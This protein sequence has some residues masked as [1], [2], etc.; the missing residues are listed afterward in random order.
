MLVIDLICLFVASTCSC[1]YMYLD[2]NKFSLLW[3][4]SSLLFAPCAIWLMFRLIIE[5]MLFLIITFKNSNIIEF[6]FS[7]I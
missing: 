6:L 3:N 7:N 2:K 4:I 5:A 1:I